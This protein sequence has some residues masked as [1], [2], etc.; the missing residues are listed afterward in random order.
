MRARKEIENDSSPILFDPILEVL[1]DIRE[2]AMRVK[3]E[4][5]L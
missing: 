5:G 2:N 3:L 1:L 4:E